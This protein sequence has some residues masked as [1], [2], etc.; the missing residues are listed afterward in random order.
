MCCENT[1]LKFKTFKLICELSLS[2]LSTQTLLG[3]HLIVS[4]LGKYI[5]YTKI[6]ITTGPRST[7]L[8]SRYPSKF[9]TTQSTQVN[10]THTLTQQRQTQQ[11][12]QSTLVHNFD[13]IPILYDF[14]G[15]PLGPRN[16]F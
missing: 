5:K 16:R 1:D 10:S 13:F 4:K 2:T 12:T 6:E 14:L 8:P 11:Q 9:P 3:F 15:I 7:P